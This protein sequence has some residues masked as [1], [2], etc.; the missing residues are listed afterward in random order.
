LEPIV[1]LIA[2]DERAFTRRHPQPTAKALDQHAML[3]VC[4]R[5]NGLIASASRVVH[6]GNISEDLMR[7]QRAVV[8]ID[9][10]LMSATKPGVTLGSIYQNIPNFYKEAGYPEE[11]KYHHQGGLSGY[12]TRERLAVETETT[13]VTQGQVYAWNPT[14]AGVK[15]EDTIYVQNNQAS[16]ITAGKHFP[17]IELKVGDKV[18]KR[19]GILQ[20]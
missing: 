5:R 4:G 19:P 20:R 9:A 18:W 11:Y 17:V 2:T 7:R 3:V 10:K 12:A 8:E 14:I 16:V 6:F 13:M 1:N 15:S